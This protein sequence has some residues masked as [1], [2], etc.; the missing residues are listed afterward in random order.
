MHNADSTY[1]EECYFRLNTGYIKYGLQLQ[2][3]I[4][5]YILCVCHFAK[6]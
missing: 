2:H 4:L 3:E 6:P 1:S 5:L